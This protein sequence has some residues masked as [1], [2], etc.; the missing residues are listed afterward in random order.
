MLSNRVTP[1]TLA[2]KI[3]KLPI[4][5]LVEVDHFV[6]YLAHKSVGKRVKS[7]SKRLAHPGFGMW[8]KQ[9]EGIDSADYASQLR[10]RAMRRADARA[11]D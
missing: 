10:K 6:E 11:S 4:Q 9:L 1:E 2:E 3:S 8:A 7:K 5:S